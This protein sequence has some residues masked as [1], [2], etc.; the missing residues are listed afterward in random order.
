MMV[1]ASASSTLI[2]TFFSG[3]AVRG[4]CGREEQKT[5]IRRIAAECSRY[6][7]SYVSI[8]SLHAIFFAHAVR[9]IG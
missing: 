6:A 8:A 1:S 4:L 9:V 5:G 2:R 3:C 7:Q